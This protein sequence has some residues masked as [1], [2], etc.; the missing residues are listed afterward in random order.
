[1]P[2]ERNVAEFSHSVVRVLINFNHLYQ[3]DRG[4]SSKALLDF[5]VKFK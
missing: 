4:I 1:M 3:R 5:R 2:P